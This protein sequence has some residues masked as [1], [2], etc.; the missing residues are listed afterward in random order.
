[1]DDVGVAALAMD[2][3]RET[4]LVF[5]IHGLCGGAN[6]QEPIWESRSSANRNRKKY[7]AP[8][9]ELEGHAVGGGIANI[10]VYLRK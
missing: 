4:I 2:A 10:T 3:P 8:Q 6:G 1:V 7:A 5:P 9:L